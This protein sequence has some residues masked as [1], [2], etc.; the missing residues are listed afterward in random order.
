MTKYL[1]RLA[2]VQNKADEFQAQYQNIQ[3][4]RTDELKAEV[5]RFR[6]GEPRLEELAEEI[7]A[8]QLRQAQLLEEIRATLITIHESSNQI[9]NGILALDA[10]ERGIS[11][12][13]AVINHR[14]L[15]YLDE[16]ESESRARLQ[17]Y[18]YYF[19]KAF[20]Y[21]VLKPYPGK[22][23]LATF[24][25]QIETIAKDSESPELTSD[26]FESL[27][28]IYE[29]EISL[30][31]STIYDEYNENR[32]IRQGPITFKLSDEQLSTINAGNEITLN[33]VEMGLFQANE[34]DIRIISLEPNEMDVEVIGDINVSASFDLKLEHSGQSFIKNKG[35]TYYF[36]HHLS[37]DTNPINWKIRYDALSDQYAIID[38]SSTN[39]SLLR[40]MLGL[41]NSPGAGED[42][43]IFSQPGAWADITVSKL[44][45]SSSD[46]AMNI[47][48]LQLTLNYDFRDS[49]DAQRNLE[50][51]V[52]DQRLKAA[53]DAHEAGNSTELTDPRVGKLWPL[54]S[55][56]RVDLNGRKDGRGHFY[57]S[58]R[59]SSSRLSL[60]A[61]EKYGKYKFVNWTD[62][63]R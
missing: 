7:Q 27:K 59:G 18:H 51:I 28:E 37:D 3:E 60:K 61:P 39:G 50:V 19:A 44:D 35:E 2:D 56:N 13:N 42:L 30:V 58:F 24:F 52:G 12:S 48:S 63:Y 14:A 31:A 21:R 23:D 16:M 49:P 9:S 41:R 25:T 54:I 10:I 22:L 43:I 45:N 46:V 4:S 20:E 6:A 29:N 15:L 62:N 11:S 34:E 33:L 57:R 38:F 53:L 5:A 1:E 40:H 36:N 26:Q 55:V 17:K 47:K 32:P 8:L